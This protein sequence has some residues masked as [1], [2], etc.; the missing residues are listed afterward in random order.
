MNRVSR[1]SVEKDLRGLATSVIARPSRHR[2]VMRSQNI[3]NIL[4]VAGVRDFVDGSA[5][6][7][8]SVSALADCY[9]G[10]RFEPH[11]SHRNYDFHCPGPTIASAPTS[12]Q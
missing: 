6:R 2:S 11:G 12:R 5:W 7:T 3:P 10:H 4:F 9:R 8:A 1:P